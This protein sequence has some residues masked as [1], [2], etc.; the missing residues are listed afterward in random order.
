MRFFYSLLIPLFLANAFAQTSYVAPTRIL[1]KKGYQLG[2]SAD[3]WATSKRV[4]KD[5]EKIPFDEGE[6]FRRAQGA[7]FGGYGLTENF[8]VSG[9]ARFRENAS[10]VLDTGTNETKNE[11]STGIE[12]TWV[13]L[14][15]AFRP[16]DRLT[17][18]LEALFRYRPFTNEESTATVPGNLILGDD[19]NEYS[20]G[21]SVT[22]ASQSAN[23]LSGRIGYRN[24][25]NDLSTEIYWQAEGAL[26]WRYAALIAGVN[27]V[28]SLNNDPYE[29]DPENKP[30]YNTGSSAL[31]SGINRDWIA[32]YAGLNVALGGSWRIELT[33]SQVVSGTSTDL[34]TSLGASL[35]R[36]IEAKS[37]VNPDRRFKDYDFE[38]SVTKVSPKK[39]YVIIDKGLS[40]DVLKG[41]KIDFFEFDYV[42]GNILLASGIVIQTKANS[43]VVKITQ[44]YNT[45]KELKEG[46]VARGVF[47]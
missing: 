12:S 21:L 43:S 46:I 26:T 7:I 19:G 36:R 11:S 44:T 1:M 42:G 40:D 41:M 35:I 29:S 13:S 45:R 24:P 32:P 22:Y 6:S 25:G 39:G 33:G 28:S 10:A 9:G 23:F 3:Y 5:G 18:A 31:Y 37:N 34:G 27:G 16:V 20:A 15:Y 47:R 14:L 30:S 38:A 8:Q 2:V 17:Y 4:D